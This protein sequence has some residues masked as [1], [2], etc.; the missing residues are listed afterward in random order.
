M[1]EVLAEDWGSKLRD[2]LPSPGVLHWEDEAPE[3][4]ALKTSKTG[5]L[6]QYS[7]LGNPKDGEAW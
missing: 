4:L 6:L 1:A 7:C 5:N 3:H 2:G